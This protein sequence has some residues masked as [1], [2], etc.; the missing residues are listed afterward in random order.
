MKNAVSLIV[1]LATVV[2]VTGFVVPTTKALQS[3]KLQM[4]V[5]DQAPPMQPVTTTISGSKSNTYV[6]QQSP[7]NSGVSNF[8]DSSSTMVSVQEYRKPTAEEIAAKKR[9]FNLWF[10]GGGFVAPFLAT[11]YYFGLKFWEK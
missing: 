10:W 11:F 9:N 6:Q 1:V 8:L 4:L 3:T 5:A 7:L 2:S